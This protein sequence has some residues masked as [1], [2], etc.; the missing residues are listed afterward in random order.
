MSAAGTI[1]DCRFPIPHYKI[2]ESEAESYSTLTEQVVFVLAIV[3]L[4]FQEFLCRKQ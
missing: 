1:F 3:N 2:Q 4:I